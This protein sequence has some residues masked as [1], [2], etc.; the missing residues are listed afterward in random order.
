VRKLF[1]VLFVVI[2]L[3]IPSYIFALEDTPQGRAEFEKGEIAGK[4]FKAAL[5]LDAYYEFCFQSPSRTG[6]Y[7]GG[8]IK[9]VKDKWGF[10]MLEMS[11][12][13][14]KETGR[15]VVHDT[16]IEVDKALE[17]IGGCKSKVIG[18]WKFMAYK[19][20]DDTLKTFHNHQ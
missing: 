16:F 1:V 15:N 18:D 14:E 5:I 17:M 9:L 19:Q 4:L 10:D 13:S 11:N 12:E 6:S 3:S 8:V 20:Y 7:T 2:L